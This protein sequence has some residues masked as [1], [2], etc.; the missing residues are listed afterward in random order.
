[1]SLHLHQW[2]LLSSLPFYFFSGWPHQW[3]SLCPSVSSLRCPSSQPA[4]SCSWSRSESA[5]QS[6]CSS[7][8][9]WSPSSTGSPISSGIWWAQQSTAAVCIS[10]KDVDRTIESLSP[11]SVLP[12]LKI[13]A[14]AII[15]FLVT[16]HGVKYRTDLTPERKICPHWLQ[17]IPPPAPPPNFLNENFSK[18]HWGGRLLVKTSMPL[19]C[20]V[21]NWNLYL[22]DIVKCG[23][24]P[25]ILMQLTFSNLNFIFIPVKLHFV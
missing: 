23:L 18:E 17:L 10:I 3:M 11:G 9:E 8:A 22:T 15:H 21:V 6:T 24:F 4:S 5:K 19:A 14:E 20:L 13:N 1:M 7:S 25:S 2:S 16:K 12:S